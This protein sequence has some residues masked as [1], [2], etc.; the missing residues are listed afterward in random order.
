M[1]V[2]FTLRDQLVTESIKN[3]ST[4]RILC[5]IRIARAELK[6]RREA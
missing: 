5:V 2:K 4:G 1:S 3:M 6:R